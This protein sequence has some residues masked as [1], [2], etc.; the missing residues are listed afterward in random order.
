M[1]AAPSA[2]IINRPVYTGLLKNR[3]GCSTQ[4]VYT[5]SSAFLEH[6]AASVV[7]PLPSSPQ[8]G[9]NSSVL[10]CRH[11]HNSIICPVGIK[12]GSANIP[13]PSL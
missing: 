3:S 4:T 10:Y 11:K 8:R 12:P 5:D 13:K 6:R 9:E 2:C 7:D 1:T